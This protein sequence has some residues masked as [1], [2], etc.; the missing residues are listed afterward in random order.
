M[1]LLKRQVDQ[2]DDFLAHRLDAGRDGR[3]ER[4]C[5]VDFMQAARARLQIAGRLASR[6][7][8]LATCAIA[9]AVTRQKLTSAKPR[10]APRRKIDRGSL[11]EIGCPEELSAPALAPCEPTR[12]K[13][14]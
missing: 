1:E 9:K 4:S 13:L 8:K 14:S 12:G 6:A 5:V 2:F 11:A 3:D 7:H 10:L